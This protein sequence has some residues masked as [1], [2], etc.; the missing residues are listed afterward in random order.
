[1][2]RRPAW[3]TVVGTAGNFSD[4][5]QAHALPH[6]AETAALRNGGYQGIERRSENIGK[7]VTWHFA[8]KGSKRKVLPNN[9]LGRMLEKIW[10]T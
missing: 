10:S 9:K 8:M 3:N 1:M 5:T 2:L 6:G 7:A 4:V